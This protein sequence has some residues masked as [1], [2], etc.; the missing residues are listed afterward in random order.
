MGQI[1]MIHPEGDEPALVQETAFD[2]VWTHK[3]FEPVTLDLAAASAAAGQQISD[4][5]R[6]DIEFVRRA[7]A[8]QRAA[9]AVPQDAEPAPAKP[10]KST[11]PTPAASS[12]TSEG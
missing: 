2:A 1:W 8:D 11:A 6:V 12:T 5:A 10:K 9:A 4:P 7:I 3:G